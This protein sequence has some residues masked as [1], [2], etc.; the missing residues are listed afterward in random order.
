MYF[1]SAKSIEAGLHDTTVW[2]FGMA[3]ATRM[4]SPTL[5][6]HFSP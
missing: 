5:S 1:L 3:T 6:R 2:T 4:P